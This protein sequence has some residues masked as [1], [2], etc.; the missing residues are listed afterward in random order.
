[1]AHQMGECEETR[2]C[3]DWTQHLY[4]RGCEQVS[5]RPSDFFRIKE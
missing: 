5:S 4:P 3:F 2:S 1:V